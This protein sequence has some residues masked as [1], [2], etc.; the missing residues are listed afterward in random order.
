[1]TTAPNAK[2]VELVRQRMAAKSGTTDPRMVEM[3]KQRMKARQVAS[4]VAADPV[5]TRGVGDAAVAGYGTGGLGIGAGV[6]RLAQAGVEFAGAVPRLVDTAKTAVG[7][8]AVRAIE[9]PIGAAYGVGQINPDAAAVFEGVATG[10]KRTSEG[11]AN[12]AAVPF[13]QAADTL[14]IGEKAV[15]AQ[16]PTKAFEPYSREW[17][18]Y[19][20]GQMVPQ[21]AGSIGGTVA[22]SVVGGPQAGLAAGFALTFGMEAGDQAKSIY[23]AEI[24]KGA[25]RESAAVAAFVPAVA[26]GL[27]NAGIEQWGV[28]KLIRT[29]Q[30]VGGIRR[31]LAEWFAGECRKYVLFS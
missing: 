28:E 10:P 23:D 6:A 29:G 14:S 8:R 3:V 31:S 22:G 21:I 30:L 7:M 26:T 24:A 11:V 13:R 17:F 2:M 18:A 9:D 16:A 4:R 27:L 20:A 12:A 19:N 25:D 15:A 5:Q 1:M